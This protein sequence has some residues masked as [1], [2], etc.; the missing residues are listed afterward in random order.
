MK[1]YI[2][3]G[4]NNFWYDIFT[5]SSLETAKVRMELIKQSPEQFS[6]SQPDTFYLYE[7]NEVHRIENN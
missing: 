1:K 5:A 7:A 4:S 2:I 6:V 3:V